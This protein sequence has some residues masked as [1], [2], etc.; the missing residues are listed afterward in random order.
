MASNNQKQIDERSELFFEYQQKEDDSLSGWYVL[1][2]PNSST[3]AVFSCGPF[4]RA[5]AA[6]ICGTLAGERMLARRAQELIR[7]LGNELIKLSN[8]E[9]EKAL[10]DLMGNI[11][12]S[13]VM[14]AKPYD[15][16]R[17]SREIREIRLKMRNRLSVAQD[18]IL[19]QAIVILQA[20]EGGLR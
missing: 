14:L 12:L 5:L 7:V 2:E 13:L 11:G 15:A 17:V 18:G 4:D 19:L 20:V 9:K 3:D 1:Y 10:Y 8:D 6:H 16:E